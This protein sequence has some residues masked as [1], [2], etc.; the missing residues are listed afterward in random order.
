MLADMSEE[1]MI[2]LGECYPVADSASFIW[3]GRVDCLVTMHSGTDCG[4][5][6]WTPSVAECYDQTFGSYRAYC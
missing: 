1:G 3:Y 4:G 6:T 2:G 5:W